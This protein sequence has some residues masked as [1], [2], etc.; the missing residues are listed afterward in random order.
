MTMK[1]QGHGKE[2]LIRRSPQTADRTSHT[3]TQC[4]WMWLRPHWILEPLLRTNMLAPFLG[5]H[6]VG[7]VAK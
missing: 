7:P 5:N 1:C 6:T 4:G 3:Y 2:N